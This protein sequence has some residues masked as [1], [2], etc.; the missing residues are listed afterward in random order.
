[1]INS[2][3][4]PSSVYVL[5]SAS[6][7]KDVFIQ[8]QQDSGLIR[9]LWFLVFFSPPALE[10]LF[11]HFFVT[12]RWVSYKKSL[13]VHFVSLIGTMPFCLPNIFFVFSFQKFYYNVSWCVVPCCWGFTK[14]LELSLAI[15]FFFPKLREFILIFLWLL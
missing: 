11:F 5:I 7:L 1:M 12:S 3:N 2:L 9:F 4:F 13:L 8:Y 14:I 10:K 6:F 15:M